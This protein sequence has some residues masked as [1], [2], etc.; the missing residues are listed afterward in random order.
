M[1][2][3]QLKGFLQLNLPAGFKTIIM[4]GIETVG[5][6]K[7]FFNR[8][9][10]LLS[11]LVFLFV[12][13][14]LLGQTVPDD[15]QKVLDEAGKNKVELEK[16]LHHYRK[17]KDSLKLRAAWFLIA[18]MN[19]QCYAKAKLV[20]TSGNR[21][22][23][24][25]LDYP[26]YKTMV[27]AWDSVEHKIGTI[28]FTRDTLIYDINIITADYLIENIDLAFKAWNKPWAQQLTFDEFC[29]YI[30]PLS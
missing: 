21:V 9:I 28:D 19:G 3:F 11:V 27:A 7:L 22:K 29:E 15:V 1:F 16:V 8:T 4:G 14:Q 17:Q 23:F 2:V 30:L 24:N 10:K 25:V 26:D 13:L 12:S 18:N 5:L 20:D 6:V